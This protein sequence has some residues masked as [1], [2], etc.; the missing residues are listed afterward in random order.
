MSLVV[1]C[2]TLL[3]IVLDSVT[4]SIRWLEP[5]ADHALTLVEV[6]VRYEPWFFN[7]LLYWTFAGEI[8]IV[9]VAVLVW[10]RRHQQL[11]A[12]PA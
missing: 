5:F 6:P 10:R 9:L 1:G 12:T 3:H 4:G 7:F 11:G 8:A 2:N